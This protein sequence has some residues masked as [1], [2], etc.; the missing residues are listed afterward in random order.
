MKIVI[1]EKQFKVLNE[2]AISSGKLTIDVASEFFH[3][4]DY[5]IDNGKIKKSDI[6]KL[7]R[8][9]LDSNSNTKT[10]KLSNDDILKYVYRLRYSHHTSNT[11][12][13]FT[14]PD[15]VNGLAYYLSKHLFGFEKS[16]GLNYVKLSMDKIKFVFFDPEIKQIVGFMVLDKVN[17]NTW[18]V[19][20]SAVD[21]TFVGRGY[22]KIM[23]LTVLNKVRKLLSDTILYKD[24]L[25]IWVN[26]L[27]KYATVFAQMKNGSIVRLTTKDFIKPE[28]VEY[29]IGTLS[30]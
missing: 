3:T 15:M 6:I 14:R 22:G 11:P 30:L 28:N 17:K 25:N 24:S 18:K 7:T 29:Y 2:V 26:I 16:M 13:D 23:Y 5:M 8:D 9:Y 27:P 21:E 12:D 1:T 4:I 10:K 19:E 20:L